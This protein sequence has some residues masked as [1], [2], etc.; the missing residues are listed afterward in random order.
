MIVFEYDVDAVVMLY[1]DRV[2]N[3]IELEWLISSALAVSLLDLEVIQD[4]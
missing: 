3:P 2:T 1:W 4:S